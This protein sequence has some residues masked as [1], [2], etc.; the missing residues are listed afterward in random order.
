MEV[1]STPRLL[2]Q[3]CLGLMVLKVEQAF[4]PSRLEEIFHLPRLVGHVESGD[5]SGSNL[6]LKRQGCIISQQGLDEFFAIFDEIGRK[7]R[8]TEDILGGRETRQRGKQNKWSEL[9]LEGVDMSRRGE[10]WKLQTGEK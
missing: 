6:Q 2:I 9:R 4:K 8:S 3:T 1:E 7:L 5:S 10:V